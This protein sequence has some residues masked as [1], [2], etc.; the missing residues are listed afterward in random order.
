MARVDKKARKAFGD[1]EEKQVSK[2]KYAML[3]GNSEVEVDGGDN[4]DR[5]HDLCIANAALSQ[6]SY[7]PTGVKTHRQNDALNYK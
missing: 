2:L 7:I 3:L 6:L 4:G 5:T 1:T